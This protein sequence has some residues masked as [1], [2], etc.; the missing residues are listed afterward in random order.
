MTEH[1]SVRE[2]LALAASG[3]LD[4]EELRRVE[5]HVRTCEA[6][7]A[8]LDVWA[9]YTQGL[10][11]LPQPPAPE[12]LLE[13]TR[14]R[15]VQEH[16]AASEK[17]R[18]EVYLAALAAFG[19]MASFALWFIV[20]GF[21]GDTLIVL[22]ANLGSGWTWFTVSAGLSWATAGT[23]ILVLGRRQIRRFL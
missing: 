5:Q 22:G 3:V 6:C 11:K 20:R 15:I 10:R 1:E 13:R 2:L 21:A 8:G 4:A 14:A 23:A 7:R 16:D 12:G 9:G 18:H 19:W 17:R